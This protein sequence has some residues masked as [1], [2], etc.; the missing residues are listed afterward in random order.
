MS[1]I[2]RKYAR[3][4]MICL[5]VFGGL[6]ASAIYF[7]QDVQGRNRKLKS[8]RLLRDYIDWDYLPFRRSREGKW[9]NSLVGIL[10]MINRDINTCKEDGNRRILILIQDFVVNEHPALSLDW[11]SDKNCGYNLRFGNVSEHHT[12]PIE[13]DLW[14]DVMKLEQRK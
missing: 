11:V 7:V 9:P 14:K 5:T 1:G 4:A 6:F 12:S 8:F 13:G 2:T 3:L 10:P